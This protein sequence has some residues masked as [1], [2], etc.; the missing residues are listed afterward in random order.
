MPNPIAITS[1]KIVRTQSAHMLVP[2]PLESASLASES[3]SPRG[4]L[5]RPPAPIDGGEEGHT[6]VGGGCSGRVPPG[7]TPAR[8]PRRRLRRGRAHGTPAR[9]PRRRL[10]RGRAD[11]TP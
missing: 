7:G 5:P 10:R 2:P 3:I 1:T 8:P 6:V 11:G 9:P 4:A